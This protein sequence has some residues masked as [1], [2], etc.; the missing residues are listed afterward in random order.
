M[1]SVSNILTATV[2]NL[3]V[4]GSM[5][6]PSTITSST[7]A[8]IVSTNVLRASTNTNIQVTSALNITTTDASLYTNNASN[9]LAGVPTTSNAISL[10]VSGNIMA[11]ALLSI[12]D[13]R[14]KNN[15][16]DSSETDDLATVLAI[17]VRRFNFADRRDESH[18]IGFIAQEIEEIAP[19]AVN[20]TTSAIPSIM[21]F[22]TVVD[23]T[24]KLPNTTTCIR[25][26]DELKLIVKNVEITA[27]VANV[28]SDT[29][30]M[31]SVVL[32]DDTNV[33]L[34]QSVFVY[35]HVV[36][37]FRLINTERILP[38]VL[39]SVKALHSTIEKQQA[40][41]DSILT[42]LDYLDHLDHLDKLSPP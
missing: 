10:R 34:S 35:G 7:T 3:N 20:T 24:F 18:T 30:N 4:T 36:S 21:S 12:S 40:M 39:N 11:Q 2:T 22:A 27:K 19:Y 1:T 13:G 31:Q 26:G 32:C 15:I 42:R 9:S 17:P 6:L 38:L 37:D 23:H 5:N 28:S 29:E 33:D 25:T 14:V 16:V 41:I 8:N